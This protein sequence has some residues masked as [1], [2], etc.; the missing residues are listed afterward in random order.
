MTGLGAGN[1]GVVAAAASKLAAVVTG[2]AGVDDQDG[3]IWHSGME[4]ADP[5]DG[6]W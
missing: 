6:G 2:A 4:S 5:G 1:P 3:E